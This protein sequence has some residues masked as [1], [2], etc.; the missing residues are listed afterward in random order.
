MHAQLIAFAVQQP[1][2]AL[3]LLVGPVRMQPPTCCAH[4]GFATSCPMYMLHSPCMQ[5]NN[6]P[7]LLI[8]DEY[9]NIIS[10]EGVSLRSRCSAFAFL[11]CLPPSLVGR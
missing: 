2:F 8:L 9:D 6:P 4:Q 11:S 3:G 1:A 5:V 7:L 10:T